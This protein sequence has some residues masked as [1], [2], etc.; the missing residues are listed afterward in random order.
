MQCY[1]LICS[2]ITICS[3]TFRP[4]LGSSSGTYLKVKVTNRMILFV[5]VTFNYVPEDDPQQGSKHVGTYSNGR[6]Y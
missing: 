2:Y 3:N 1:L 5:I 4:L 6:T